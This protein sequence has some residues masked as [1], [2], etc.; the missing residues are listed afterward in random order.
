MIRLSYPSWTIAIALAT[1]ALILLIIDI[2]TSIG[3]A[4]PFLYILLA[5]FVVA[6]RSRSAIYGS[7]LA[8]IILSAI[9]SWVPTLKDTALSLKIYTVDDII[10]DTVINRFIAVALFIAILAL[11]LR[12]RKVQDEMRL[13]S[14]TDP[15]TGALNR[16]SFLDLVEIERSRLER[17]GA[18]LAIL[19]LDIDFFKRVND[20]FGHASGDAAIRELARICQ[21]ALR[22]GDLFAR[23]GGEEFIVALPNTDLNEALSAAE[24]LRVML[25]ETSYMAKGKPRSFTVSIGVSLFNREEPAIDPVVDRAD[26][27]LYRA[28]ERGRNRVESDHE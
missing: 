5:P 6:L 8:V 3:V 15:L 9:G 13:L 18:P 26:R 16:R 14:T 12:I 17:S 21:L 24:R 2:K 23:W 1:F 7:I 10:L 11:L 25:S 28:K 27:A 20:Q 4:I 22:P 19:L